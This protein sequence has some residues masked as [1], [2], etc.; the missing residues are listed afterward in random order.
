M[1]KLVFDLLEESRLNIK[2]YRNY[3][4]SNKKVYKEN[5]FS[6]ID[7]IMNSNDILQMRQLYYF[8]D[9][10][11][12]NRDMEYIFYF[13]KKYIRK[14]VYMFID[15]KGGKLKYYIKRM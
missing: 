1:T 14:F 9:K 8:I 12:E 7:Y 11:A 4:C 3:E 6:L 13:H 2:I 10:L 15:D 5:C